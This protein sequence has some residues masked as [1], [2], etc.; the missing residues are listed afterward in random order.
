[1]RLVSWNVNG[2]RAVCGKGFVPWLKAAAPDILCLQE[3]RA[4]RG[5][6][7]REAME[8]TGYRIAWT[9]AKKGGYS[10]VATYSLTPPDEVWVGLGA[11][12]F[13]D[14]GRTLVTRHGELIVI[15][16]YFPNS[17]MDHARLPY[18]LDYCEAVLRLAQ[19]H[20]DEGS[21]VVIC[22]DLNIA[23]TP[24]D[25]ANPQANRGAAGFLPQE[26]AMM[27]AYLAAGF[28]DVFRQQNPDVTG[29][30]TWWSNRGGAREKN[31][32][33]R[34]DYHLASRDLLARVYQARILADVMGSDHC[35]VELEL[36]E[37]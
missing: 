12:R 23:H 28:V 19:H 3:V 17:Q 14:E 35:P 6:A 31:V 7:P 27:D 10:G 25:L 37:D 24:K 15:N 2:I 8:Y 30:Y 18:K 34:I 1:M 11:A 13:D 21:S 36:S 32:G 22:G 29:A 16:G 20:Q 5:Q 9:S 26:R 4:H 33:W